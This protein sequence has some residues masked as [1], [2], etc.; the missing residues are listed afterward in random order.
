MRSTWQA[1]L[2]TPMPGFLTVAV[3]DRVLRQRKGSGMAACVVGSRDTQQC[4]CR[5]EKPTPSEAN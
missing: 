3:D 2:P 1:V 5:Q 4:G